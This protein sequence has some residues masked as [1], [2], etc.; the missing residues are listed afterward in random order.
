M[1]RVEIADKLAYNYIS[2][3]IEY[4]F[5]HADPHSGNLRIRDDKIVWIDFGMMGILEEE[6]VN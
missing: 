6:I 3:V 1:T 2:Q 5:F 4:G